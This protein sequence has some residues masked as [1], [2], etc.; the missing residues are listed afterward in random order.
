MNAELKDIVA[1]KDRLVWRDAELDN[2]IK[3]K[4]LNG[5]KKNYPK[6]RT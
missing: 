1:L 6:N 5:N 2:I 4:G 3:S